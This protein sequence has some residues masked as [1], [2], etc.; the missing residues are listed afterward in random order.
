MRERIGD[1]TALSVCAVIVT[2]HPSTDAVEHISKVLAQV[3]ELVVVDNG[4]TPG[5]ISLLRDASR[6]LGFHVVE[7]K[8]N[9]GIAEALNQGVRWAKSSGYPWVILFDQDSCIT[10]GFVR[11]M[12]SVWG[13]HPQRDRVA[14]IHPRYFYPET[15]IE[16]VVPRDSLGGPILPMTS[17]ALMP[18]WI[19]DKIGWFASEYFIDFVDWEYCFRIRAAGYLVAD[20]PQT[21]LLHAPG[22]PA[23][24][25][26]LG[27]TFLLSHHN[28]TR[29]YYISRNCIPFYRKYFRSFPR[30]VLRG[31]YGQ[32]KDT[33]VCLIA[34][35]N[36]PQKFRSILLGIWD[37]LMG[38]MGKR[39]G[40]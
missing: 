19:F 10:D 29:R 34:E 40:V 33:L 1:M 36:R 35:G 4:S 28:A 18:T 31:V 3:R 26:I 32:F 7:N 15:G 23:T 25:T 30:W 9:L 17:G 21:A 14:S 20:S 12:L 2:Y 16:M 27:H 13:S 11:Q 22:D 5:E 37:G 6:T 8:Q 38:R 39:E 24:R